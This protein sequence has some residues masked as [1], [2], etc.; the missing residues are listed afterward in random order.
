M[1]TSPPPPASPPPTP[2]DRTGID[3]DKIAD[4]CQRSANAL[5]SIEG[6]LASIATTLAL[7]QR[8]TFF[9]ALEGPPKP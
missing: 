2:Q 6:S 3:M 9:R 5:E 8:A 4:G 7:M 1:P